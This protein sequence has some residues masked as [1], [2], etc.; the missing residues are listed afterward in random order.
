[1]IAIIVQLVGNQ[2]GPSL[3]IGHAVRATRARGIYIPH[4]GTVRLA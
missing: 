1:M 3:A 2:L 4:S